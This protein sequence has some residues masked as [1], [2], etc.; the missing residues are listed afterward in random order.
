MNIKQ[1]L[2]IPLVKNRPVVLI[3]IR[4]SR[5]NNAIVIR[6]FKDRLYRIFITR[7]IIVQYMLASPA[8]SF[9]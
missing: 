4:D 6:I 5:L 2:H 1:E 8:M 3:N 9:A 7:E